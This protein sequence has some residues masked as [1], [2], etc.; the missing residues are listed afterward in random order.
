MKPKDFNGG[1]M[2]KEI[3]IKIEVDVGIRKA[4]NNIICGDRDTFNR[5]MGT[6]S[7]ATN[8][9]MY[10]GVTKKNNVWTIPIGLVKERRFFLQNRLDNLLNKID[11]I[12]EVL[13]KC[14]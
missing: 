11:F 10:K 5:L 6:S 2:E 3:K 4:G 14:I 1:R 7:A 9:H 12:E 8:L 13:K